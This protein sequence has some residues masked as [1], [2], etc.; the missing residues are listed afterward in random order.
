M[1]IAELLD[2]LPS[3]DRLRELSIALAVL[4]VALSPDDDP[5]DRYFRF[6]PRD[7]SGMALASMDN[8]SG[9]RYYIA[10]TRD[11]VF[12]WGFA[13]EA[14]MSPF[15]RT[16]V[17]LWPGLLDGMPAEFEPLTRDARFQIADTFMA[18]AAF[19]SEDGQ[20]WHS[21]SA[22]PPTGETDADGAEELFELI[23]DDSPQAFERFAQDYL[24]MDPSEAAISAVYTSHPLDPSTLAELNPDADYDDLREQLHAMG[25]PAS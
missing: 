17:S 13:H 22:T 5:E 24:E 12:G 6:D 15:T 19:W 18:T 10:F 16:P 3:P 23:L 2:R 21:G 20:T 4:D 11:A 8:G 7:T 1:T 14:P 9:D 25:L